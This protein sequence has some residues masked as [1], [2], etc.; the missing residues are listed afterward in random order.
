M[1]LF[2]LLLIAPWAVLTAQAAD[3]AFPAHLTVETISGPDS[4]YVTLLPNGTYTG[5][6]ID[7][8]KLIAK[9]LNF[10]YTIIEQPEKAYG[11]PQSDGSWNGLIGDLIKGKA[12]LV[13]VDLSETAARVRV[14]DFT[15]PFGPSNLRILVNKEFGLNNVTY[16]VQRDTSYQTYLERS[17][18]PLDKV[19]WANI[20]TNGGIQDGGTQPL[21]DKVLAGGFALFGDGNFLAPFIA[22]RPDKLA[23]DPRIVQTGFLGFAVPLGSPI[24]QPICVAISEINESGNLQVLFNKYSLA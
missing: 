15:T 3:F 18:N 10:T 12:D 22:A 2:I 14:V 17:Q 21:V 8:M 6:V 1:N 13:A 4:A 11:V 24:R 19:I 7:L 16:L 5:F 23:F 9:N 20:I